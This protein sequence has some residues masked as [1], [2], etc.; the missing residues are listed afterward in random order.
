MTVREKELAEHIDRFEKTHLDVIIRGGVNRQ[1]TKSVRSHNIEWIRLCFP[2]F[3]PIINIKT[4][5]LNSG[6]DPQICAF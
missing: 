6:I 1:Q 2:S 3:T 4:F 5:R